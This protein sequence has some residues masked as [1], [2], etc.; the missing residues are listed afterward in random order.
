MKEILRK[1]VLDFESLRP[2]MEA[3]SEENDLDCHFQDN[4]FQVKDN[5]PQLL[6]SFHLPYVLEDPGSDLE[7][8]IA[9]F[10]AEPP[11]YLIILIQAGQAALGYFEA[12]EVESHKV[13]RKY[14]IRAKQGKS[15]LNHLKT[16]GKS[17]LGSRIRLSQTEAFFEEINSKLQDWEMGSCPR[18]Y[19]SA[20]ILLWNKM[21]ETEPPPPFEKRDLRLRA[22]PL[23]LPSPN[24]EVLLDVNL[25][26]LK[27]Q[28]SIYSP[29]AMNYSYLWED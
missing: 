14:M 8:L 20:S 25:F 6:F 13:I 26:L 29:Q 24:Y 28:L 23:D 22:I 17:R 2:F 18:I 27:G 1:E 16:K 4:C 10:P 15:Q 11:D 12:G 5:K 19:Y 7:A 9:H 3:L 21:F